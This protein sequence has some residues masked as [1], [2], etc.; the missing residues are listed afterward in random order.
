MKLTIGKFIVPEDVRPTDNY[1]LWVECMMGDADGYNENTI[2]TTR[3]DDIYYFDED[4]KITL[5]DV[6]KLLLSMVNND[7]SINYSNRSS[8]RK[9]PRG[10]LEEMFPEKSEEYIDAFI[11]LLYDLF[12]TDAKWEGCLA[13]PNE[14][15]LTYFDENKDEY[16]VKIEK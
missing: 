16:E 3:V 2:E 8:F 1:R 6:I 14:W 9:D 5:E 7:T 4:Y 13:V 10:Y 15:K 12:D 11:E